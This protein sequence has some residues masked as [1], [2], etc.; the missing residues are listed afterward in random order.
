[1]TQDQINTKVATRAVLATRITIVA[2]LVLGAVIV[3]LQLYTTLNIREE[4][5]VSAE[6]GKSI[7]DTAEA[8]ESCTTPEGQCFKDSQRRTGEAV[9]SIAQLS[10]YASACA[11]DVDPRLPVRQRVRIIQRC[12]TQ[13]AQRP[14][15]P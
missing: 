7:K 15:S 14:D 4:Q 13:L 11:A 1:M 6:R 5:K 3:G 10:V 8:V 9:S 12:V 2:A